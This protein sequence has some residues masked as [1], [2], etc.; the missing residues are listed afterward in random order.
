MA[1]PSARTTLR[2]P[3]CVQFRQWLTPQSAH[4]G[5][6]RRVLCRISGLTP[7]STHRAIADRAL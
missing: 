4:R 7:Q 5:A 6:G 2:A 3:P 1:R